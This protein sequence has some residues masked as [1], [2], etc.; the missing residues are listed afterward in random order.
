MSAQISADVRA[1]FADFE[2]EFE[3]AG[4]DLVIDRFEHW[5]IDASVG[6]VQP[7]RGTCFCQVDALEAA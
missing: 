4:T 5:S 1:L 6:T 3:K 2:I 7:R